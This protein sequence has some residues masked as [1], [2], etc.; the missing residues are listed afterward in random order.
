[1]EKK[2]MRIL[3][4]GCLVLGFSSSP[5]SQAGDNPVLIGITQLVEHPA[6]DAVRKGFMDDLKES[7]ILGQDEGSCEYK[8]AQNNRA[9]SAQIAKSL[10]GAKATLVLAIS[11]PS[12]QDMAAVT[13]DIPILFAA[14]TDPV[15]AG[16]VKS[17]LNP[18]GNVSGTTDLSPVDKQLGLCMEIVGEIRLRRLGTIYNAGEVNSV[19][20]VKE[21]R[22]EAARRNIVLVEV[23]VTSSGMVKMG[24]ES[25]VGK[26]DAIHVPTDNTVVSALESVVKVCQ[27]N[28]IPL[29]AADTD[30]V[31]RG[32][33][34][35]LAV[36]Y[37]K[38]G[39]Q[40]GAMARKILSGKVMISNLPVESQ[41][42]MLLQLNPGQAEKMG[43]RL[44]EGVLKRASKIV[45]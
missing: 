5:A 16:L 4:F 43:V 10:V 22:Y 1:V 24:A 21:L 39:R 32:A 12:A 26:V 30:S 42:E 44:S 23:P 15:A 37:Y 18:G 20:S 11:T 35:A 40:T 45:Q 38:L 17:L 2:A 3:L 33:I 7:G 29:F 6:L 25:L 41:E 8:N 28:K 27:D 31:T 34:A 14:V 9:V 13:K 19:A 36:D